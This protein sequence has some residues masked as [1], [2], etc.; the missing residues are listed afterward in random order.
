MTGAVLLLVDVGGCV[1]NR[2]PGSLAKLKPCR[3]NGIDEE[4]F[5]GKLTVFENRETRTGRT[6]D[7]NIVVLPAFDQKNKA[8]PLF[9]LAGGP[10]A[11]STERADFWA[12]PGKD[13]R[14]RHDV[15]L[16]DQRGTGQS[17]RLAI[18]RDKTPQYYLS[19]MFP[20]DYVQKMRNE[21]EQRANLTKYT[22]SIAMDDLDDVRAW[23]GY[24]KINLFG[25]SYGTRAVLVYMRQ[26]P[27]TCAARSCWVSRRLI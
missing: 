2:L 9:D 3:M 25:T 27:D 15:V 19:E 14:R 12:G 21:L 16:V 22:T 26:H 13:Y 1:K 20:V 18:P 24:D 6:I 7:L 8:D 10:G 4:L 17:N 23:L 11:S 5:C